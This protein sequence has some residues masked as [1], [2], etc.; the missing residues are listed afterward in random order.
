MT[1]ADFDLS[2]R[3]AMVTGSTRGLGW[4]MTRALA[5][6]GASVVVHGRD[7]AAVAARV[8]GLR[9]EGALVVDSVCFDVTD[10][11][12]VAAGIA[13]VGARQGRLDILVNNAGGTVRKPVLEQTDA[14]WNTVIE[15][16]LSAPFRCAREALRLM[17]PQG[18]GR[19]VMISSIMGHLAR[20]T[21]PGYVAAKTGLHGLVRALAVEVAPHGVTVNALAPGYMEVEGSGTLKR[22]PVLGPWI[23][24][25]T[26]MGRWGRPE[27]LG[28][29]VV[30]LCSEA[31]AFVTGSVLTI[32]GGFTASL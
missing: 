11:A 32:D 2:G 8:E 18:W 20:P 3:V 23:L 15:T 10:A 12:A 14:D 30:F 22:D 21:I 28:G 16:D 29:A 5:A 4:A 13:A 31:A 27:E 7:P 1:R 17:L 24:S 25:S 6:Q 9:A 19:I 26:P